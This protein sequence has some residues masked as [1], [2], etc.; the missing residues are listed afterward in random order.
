MVEEGEYEG[1]ENILICCQQCNMTGDG[2]ELVEW[3]LGGVNR[4]HL[5]DDPVAVESRDIVQAI[6]SMVP[7]FITPSHLVL[8]VIVESRPWEINAG[9]AMRRSERACY[10]DGGFTNILSEIYCNGGQRG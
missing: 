9:D 5:E 7:Q 4:R 2:E 1:V 6:T 3:G 8:D 10:G